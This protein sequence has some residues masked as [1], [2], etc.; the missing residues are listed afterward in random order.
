MNTE[1]KGRVI[2]SENYLST[3]ENIKLINNSQSNTASIVKGLG[4][5]VLKGAG[6]IIRIISGHSTIK[7]INL[8]QFNKNS[9]FLLAAYDE[10]ILELN[11]LEGKIRCITHCSVL[12]NEQEY[13]PAAFVT[14]KF[15]TK[16]KII[17]SNSTSFS[18]VIYTED[19]SKSLNEEYVKERKYFLSKVAPENSFLFIDG[20]MFSGASTAGNFT[21]IESL[22][23]QNC[24]PVFFVKNSE[25][26]IITESF[27]FAK[28]Y[29][30]DLHWAFLNL[31]VGEVSPIFSYISDDGRGKAMCFLK[32]FTGRSPIRIEFPLRAFLDGLYS[33]EIFNLIYYQ[34]L[35]NGSGI[36]V[37]PRIVQIAELYAREIL[38]STNLYNEIERM[39]LTKSMNEQRGF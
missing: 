25:S 22:L 20:S 31:K 39:G 10:S 19:L 17:K 21:L 18:D 24:K 3:I 7:K 38:K 11:S 6:S 16:S 36:N 26:T 29:N 35:A 33:D 4:E 32:V 13:T 14:L 15:F 1:F 8:E 12:Q 37:Q 27:D 2:F 9:T 23:S 28:G 30:S 5:D 34:F